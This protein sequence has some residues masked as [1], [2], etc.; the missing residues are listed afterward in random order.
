M[1]Y[2]NQPATVILYVVL[3][4]FLV[5]AAI[6]F[7]AFKTRKK[8][9]EKELEK[10]KLEIEYQRRLGAEVN[11]AQEKERQRIAKDFHDEIGNTLA[12][13]NLNLHVLKSSTMNPLQQSEL[14]EELIVINKSA[15]EVS[16]KIV[17]NLMPPVLENF[18]FAE[19]IQQL[20]NNFKNA[21]AIK[22]EINDVDFLSAEKEYTLQLYRVVQELFANTMKHSEATEILISFY[23]KHGQNYCR[24]SDNG[25]GFVF[26]DKLRNGGFGLK[27]ICSR[28]DFLGGNYNV[29]LDLKK[30]FEIVFDFRTH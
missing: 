8:F 10:R 20:V 2:E 26:T 6:I 17:H 15:A 19:A 4:L 21:P 12:A 11:L 24:Y 27:N 30:G 3:F 7:F 9:Y 14:I 1:M 29:N 5:S 18:G 13:V 23:K 16:R 25:K 28:I 22:L